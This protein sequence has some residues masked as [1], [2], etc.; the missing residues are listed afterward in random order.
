VCS[1][2]DKN[3]EGRSLYPL[4]LKNRRV[5]I[6]AGKVVVRL[7]DLRLE[8]HPASLMCGPLPRIRLQPILYA[9]RTPPKLADNIGLLLHGLTCQWP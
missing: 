9:T 7:C 5:G 1:G 6:I 2:L 4:D 3:T 8:T